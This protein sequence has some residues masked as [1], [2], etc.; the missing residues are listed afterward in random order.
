MKNLSTHID[1][2]IVS[3]CIVAPKGHAKAQF[4]GAIAGEVAGSVGRGAAD[5]A[6]ARSGSASPLPPGASSL[7][8]LAV[9]DEEIVLLTVRRGMIKPVATGVAGRVPRESIRGAE[10]GKAKLQAPLRLEWADGSSWELA[11]PRS[12]VKKARALVDRLAA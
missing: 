7:G 5:T 9:T 2:P 8:M 3:S 1:D 12:D 11:V 6:S 4:V 10:L